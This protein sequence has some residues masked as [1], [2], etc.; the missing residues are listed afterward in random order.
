[1]AING[2]STQGLKHSTATA[3]TETE[4]FGLTLHIFRGPT[5]QYSIEAAL[6]RLG[7]EIK[8]LSEAE[9]SAVPGERSTQLFD[10]TVS[11]GPTSNSYQS[12]QPI[13]DNSTAGDP[14][15]M[16]GYRQNCSGEVNNPT[17][18]DLSIQSKGG[19]G[20]PGYYSRQEQTFQ[21]GDTTKRVTE[22]V[23]R[24]KLG[25]TTITR[26]VKSET[27]NRSVPVNE[28]V[29]FGQPSYVTTSYNDGPAGRYQDPAHV[30]DEWLY[31]RNGGSNVRIESSYNTTSNSW[32]P[33]SRAQPASNSYDF[34][35]MINDLE[36]TTTWNSGTFY[37]SSSNARGSAVTVSRSGGNWTGQ[38][39]VEI[40]PGSEIQIQFQ[41]K[42]GRTQYSSQPK[43]ELGRLNQGAGQSNAQYGSNSPN[44]ANNSQYMSFGTSYGTPNKPVPVVQV[45]SSN[46]DRPHVEY[47]AAPI[48]RGP[49]IDEKPYMTEIYE[50]TQTKR[51]IEEQDGP[52]TVRYGGGPA[53]S[54][55]RVSNMAG[56]SVPV[57]L[58]RG[59]SY[60]GNSPSS[61]SKTP[62][63]TQRQTSHPGPQSPQQQTQPPWAS[64]QQSV[65]QGY[66]RQGSQQGFNQQNYPAQSPNSSTSNVQRLNSLQS[67]QSGSETQNSY[68]N[69]QYNSH[70]QFGG[71]S[72]PTDNY[73]QSYN[74]SDNQRGY[75]PQ[76]YGQSSQYQNS[77]QDPYNQGQYGAPSPQQNYNQ[78]SYGDSPLQQ[79]YNQPPYGGQPSPQSYKQDQ[80]G[81]YNQGPYGSPQNQNSNFN[82]GYPGNNQNSWETNSAWGQNSNSHLPYSQQGPPSAPVPPPP[83]NAPPAPPPPPSET[84]IYGPSAVKERAEV[85][86]VVAHSVLAPENR[87]SKGQS[88]FLKRRANSE[89]W[90]TGAGE[91][92]GGGADYMP[93][94]NGSWGP[95]RSDSYQGP[96]EY[97]SHVEQKPSGPPGGSPRPGMGMA[98]QEMGQSMGKG[99]QLFAKKKERADKWAAADDAKSN[100]Q[101]PVNMPM[102]QQRSY[103][104]M[105]MN[106]V[107]GGPS[108]Q[109]TSNWS[110]AGQGGQ[111]Y[112]YTDL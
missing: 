107:S 34:P 40:Q 47:Q 112:G 27:S 68:G 28:R 1:M 20:D 83:G 29:L 24:D 62:S 85:A 30:A 60:Q 96:S 38:D 53:P 111:N 95:Q 57:K 74:Q 50:T 101:G 13:F 51:T 106:V 82:Q 104:P 18:N 5:A 89:K 26:V 16:R 92:M 70:G 17:F 23:S 56:T 19:P 12:F 88:M 42:T 67:G 79:N 58:E 59:T 65:G 109:Q 61:P 8:T 76:N 55:G 21:E 22:E 66:Q 54:P 4:D 14:P 81:G 3:L 64:S 73:P 110:T 35:R 37:P 86:K 41:P 103:Q 32:S 99:A 25:G 91:N 94:A 7:S 90:T 2:V 6:Q 69:Q 87:N 10:N 97:S 44:E 71:P 80:Y 43:Y 49:P 36:N 31:G 108:G 93:S 84:K 39:A 15:T 98:A 63:W 46:D 102:Q 11:G 48:Q 105:K 45:V 77:S 78:W 9:A 72:G 100:M 75:S 33:Q 52:V